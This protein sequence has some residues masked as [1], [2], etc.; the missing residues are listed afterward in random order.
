M[1]L[2]DILNVNRIR[3]P[4]QASDK[5]EAIRE[6]IDLLAGHGDVSDAETMVKAVLERERTRTTGIG[7]G[8]ALP[9]GKGPG[10][11]ELVMAMGVADEPIDFESVDGQPV[12]LVI[13]LVSPLDKTGPHIQALARVSRLLSIDHFRKRLAAAKTPEEAYEL[14]DQREQLPD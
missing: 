10:A 2:T 6:L 13:L 5:V 9:H 7:H 4:L 1:R 14:I 11:S 12:N 3:V 8:I